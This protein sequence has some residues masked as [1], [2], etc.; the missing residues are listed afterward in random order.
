ME[1][2]SRLLRS[3]WERPANDV[4]LIGP[5]HFD[6]GIAEVRD[7]LA[8]ISGMREVITKDLWDANQ[9]AHAPKIDQDAGSAGDAHH[10]AQVGTLLLTA[11]LSNSP[12]AVKG[13][14]R[15]EIVECLVTPMHDPGDFLEA[16]DQLEASCW[17]L[18]HTPEERYYFDRNE[19]LTKLLQNLATN[20]SQ[21]K[22]DD[23]I[24][25]RL[26]TM[27]APKRRAAYRE[28]M[29]LPELDQV[30]D[31]VKR[32]RV[33]I[34]YD[35]DSKMPP[36]AVARF[37]EEL[38]QKN[39]FLVLTGTITAMAKVEP[40][41]RNVFAAKQAATRIRTGDA[42]HTELDARTQQYEQDFNSTLL[43]V[44]DRLLVPIQRPGQAPE[45]R[46]R[47]LAQQ[48]SHNE[49]YDG[50]KLIEQSL[51][52]DPPKMYDD[53]ENHFDALRDKAQDLL[54]P[55]N[56]DEARWAD[57]QDRYASQP[58]MPWMPPKGLETLRDIA[59]QQGKW[60]DLNNGY[61]SKNPKKKKSSVQVIPEQGPD[62]HGH[63]RLRVQPQNG[64]PNP[65]IY[66]AEDSPVTNDN[67][68]L[69]DDEHLTT[70]ALRV[71]FLV[72]DP[73]ELFETGDPFVWKNQLKIRNHLIPGDPRRVELTV[74]PRGEIRY[75]LDGSEPRNG[76][77]YT[78][79]FDIGPLEVKILT[80]AQAEGLEAK[81][82]FNFAAA[83]QNQVTIDKAKPATLQ[84]TRGS[85]KKLD[86]R[87]KIFTGL[88]ELR[89]RQTQLIG[90][91]L[92]VGD[93][94]VVY[95]GDQAVSPE[96][97]LSVLTAVLDNEQTAPDNPITL[98]LKEADFPTGLDLQQF[99]KAVGVEIGEGEVVQA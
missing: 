37:F 3:V 54:W 58:A 68:T 15:E 96:Y 77:P 34:I 8:D 99:C 31:K 97:V 33:L 2:V 75:T 21:N 16:F 57:M 39:N 29:P 6:L 59:V 61:I 88:K 7:K 19:N 17:Y 93:S 62:D 4:Y 13:L 60:E 90:V 44:F 83:G 18:H 65:K 27:F 1:L 73:S 78:E 26:T 80:F 47:P 69:L 71:E 35:P 32:E 10:A 45:L 30:V 53:V 5:Q 81:E 50:E 46:D 98:A 41:A 12:N 28:L 48:R 23:E 20:A 86:S 55:P 43:N 14:T 66:Y 52:D 38:P 49:P 87:E 67:R 94:I 51:L 84:S 56:T 72:V 76:T 85:G 24:R 91:T 92:T 25:D 22:V 70:N 82:A 79:P 95:F 40:A 64:G 9:S 36:E 42:Q 63:V 74:V 89:E 11:S